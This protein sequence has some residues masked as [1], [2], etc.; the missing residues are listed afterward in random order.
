MTTTETTIGTT[1]LPLFQSAY[2]VDD[3]ETAARG[4]VT[5][6]DVLNSLT[7]ARLRTFLKTKRPR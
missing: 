4:W 3:I 6:D 1:V 5:K 2:L 7:P